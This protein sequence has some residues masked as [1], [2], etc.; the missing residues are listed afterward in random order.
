[1]P[2]LAFWTLSGLYLVLF[3]GTEALKRGA[4]ISPVITRKVLHVASA[5]VACILPFWLTPAEIVGMAALFAGVLALSKT[6]KILSSIHDVPRKTWGEVVF[7]LGIALVACY[8]YGLQATPEGQHLWGPYHYT[9][10]DGYFF[11]MLVLGILDVGAEWGGRIP[12]P[13]WPG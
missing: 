3:G 5:L 11:G 9:G 6:F 8:V 2:S 7:P 1:M 13:K 4:G 10:D 12:S